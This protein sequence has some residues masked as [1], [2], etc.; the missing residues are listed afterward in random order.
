MGTTVTAIPANP[1]VTRRVRAYFAPVNRA[2]AA[3]TWFDPA[4]SGGFALGTPPAPWVDLGWVENFA[5]K[6]GSKIAPLRSGVPATVQSQVRQEMEAT[7]SLRFLNWGKLQM[8]LTAGSQH[9]NLLQAQSGAVANGS[10]GIGIAAT[11]LQAGSTATHL[12]LTA[13]QMSAF[14]VEQMV[15]VD[16]D[17]TGQTGYVGSGVSAAYVKSAAAVQSDVNYIRRVTFNV[18]RVTAMDSTGLLLAE[19]LLAGV[20]VTGMSVQPVVGFVDRE[21]GS[22]FQEWSALFVMPGEQG[23]RVIY[24]YPRL[25]SLQSAAEGVQVLS[26]PLERVSLAGAFRALPVTDVNDAEQ[27]LCFRSYLPAAMSQLW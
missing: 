21:G 2:T 17:Y 25:Q 20:P 24:H 22:F 4:Q 6:S 15:A 1:P 12:N 8:A 16:V 5:R 18:G 9:M 27:V 19:P 14:S 3:P 23:D 7:V 10:G 11:P 26:A 13:A